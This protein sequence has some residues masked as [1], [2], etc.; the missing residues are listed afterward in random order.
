MIKVLLTGDSLVADHNWQKRLKGYDV[1]N[2]GMAGAVTNDLLSLIPLIKKRSPGADII[3]V[4]IGTNDMLCGNIAFTTFLKEILV[5]LHNQ[6]PMAEILVNSLFPM[7]L[8]H[9]PE[10]II[11]DVNR[12]IKEIAIKT[13]SCFLDIHQR[14]LLSDKTIFQEDGVHLTENAYEIWDRMLIEHIAFLIEDD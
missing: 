12:R 11:R 3:M 4:M 8:P 10:D 13:G 9:L 1:N 7:S 6:Y 2:L 14:V 5:K